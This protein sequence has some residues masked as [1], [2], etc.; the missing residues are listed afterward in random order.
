MIVVWIK[1]CMSKKIILQNRVSIQL[2]K[3][4]V[5]EWSSHAHVTLVAVT[6]KS[7]DFSI[8]TGSSLMASKAIA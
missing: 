8:Q 2:S 6:V 7:K 5:N 1:N 3:D 4:I